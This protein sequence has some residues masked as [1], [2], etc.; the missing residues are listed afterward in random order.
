[1]VVVTCSCLLLA[2]ACLAVHPTVP[3][4]ATR[5]LAPSDGNVEVRQVCAR[6]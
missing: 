6:L 4:Y 5:H 1:M 2:P 3:S